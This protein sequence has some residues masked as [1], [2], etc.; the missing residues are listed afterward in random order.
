MKDLDFMSLVE[1]FA[2]GNVENAVMDML[3]RSLDMVKREIPLRMAPTLPS[4]AATQLQVV[5]QSGVEEV[6]LDQPQE[7]QGGLYTNE[8]SSPALSHPRMQP[9]TDDGAAAVQVQV[10]R[11]ERTF[12][13]DEYTFVDV[14]GHTRKTTKKDWNQV[15][16]DGRMVWVHYGKKTT[17]ISDIRIK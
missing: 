16:Y 4:Q 5:Q 6:A 1:L 13:P 11:I 3:P 2:E 10:Q 8:S 7:D 17:Y 14:K 15:E 12:H 9:P